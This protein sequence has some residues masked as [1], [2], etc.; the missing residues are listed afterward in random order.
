MDRTH[1]N[2]DAVSQSGWL[3]ADL[4][5]A[6][7][8]VFLATV[9]FVPSETFPKS[10]ALVN[11]SNLVNSEGFYKVYDSKSPS[12]LK[13]DILEFRRE[14]MLSS[15]IVVLHL[16]FIGST[17]TSSERSGVIDALDFSFA[18]MSANLDEFSTASTSI[19]ISETLASGQVAVR[20]VFGA[21]SKE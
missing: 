15:R 14:S 3:F 4:L 20:A 5:V 6:L 16:Q 9:S 19:E 21:P 2:E 11:E 17:Q 10:Q 12:K 8:V 7:S 13:A 18:V 1:L